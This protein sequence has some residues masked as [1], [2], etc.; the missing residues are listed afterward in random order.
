VLPTRARTAL[1]RALLLA[2]LPFQV[3]AAAAPQFEVVTTMPAETV[4]SRAGTRDAATVWVEMI[5][6]AR[7]TLDIAEFYLAAEAGEALEPVIEAVLAA[8]RRGVAVR[9]LYD[10][11]MAAT[12]PGTLARLRGQPGISPRPFDW[13]RLTGGVLHA[14][15]FVVDGREAYVGSQNFDWR[16]LSHIHETGLRIGLLPIVRAL[17]Q[18]FEADWSF[19]GGDNGAYRALAL[20]APLPFDADA[21]LVASP[22]GCNPPG[23][24]S[25]LEALVGLLDKA[26]R[27][28]TVQLL[29]YST[30]GSRAAGRFVLIDEALRRAAGRGVSVCLLVSDWNLRQPGLDSLRGLARV[31]NIEVRFA[32]IPPARCGFIPYAR[33]IHSKVLRVDDDVCW[34]GT[35]NWGYDYFFQS[36]NVEV[37]LR[38]P[39]V[40]R[41]LDELFL[42]L[43]DGP[44]AQRLDPDK[45]YSPPRIN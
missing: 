32:V 9:V 30:A 18:L 40:A 42:S 5:A 27:R 41:V 1:C 31:P 6:A 28:I 11:G 17:G 45:K 16:S 25:A 23:V 38:R 3:Q 44:Y 37:V 2:W 15:Y 33:V 39:A 19:A 26:R 24:A 21:R 36:R 12:Y 8:G 20:R 34:V 13:R 43:W 10:A 29:S 7:R 4:V 35:S 14:K 22:A